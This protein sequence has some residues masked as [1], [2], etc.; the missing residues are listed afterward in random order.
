MPGHVRTVCLEFFGNAQEAVPSIVEIKNYLDKKPGGALLAG[1]E[2]LDERYLRAVGYGTKSKRGS[3]PKMVLIGDIV[4]DDDQAVAKAASEVIR[5]ANGHA[6]E[7]FVAISPE[8]RKAFWSERARTAAIARHTN[9]FKINEDVV[10]P[11]PRMGEYTN[12]IEHINIELS[13][14]NKLK[15]IT[16]C[17]DV[18]VASSTA[19][20]LTPVDPDDPDDAEDFERRISLASTLLE[21]THGRWA[22]LLANLQEPV[23]KIRDQLVA[24]EVDLSQAPVVERLARAPDCRLVDLIQEHHIRVSWKRELREPMR[25]IFSGAAFAALLEKLEAS[26]KA[27]LRSRVFIALHLHAGDGN[28]HT[29][30]PVNSDDYEMLQEA[31]RAV[32]RVMEI[33]KSLDG[34]I[35]GEHGIGITKMEFLTEGE[36]NAFAEYK[37]KVDP[38]QHFNAGK[39]LRGGNLD[40]AYTPSFGLMGAESL[41]MQQSDIGSIADSFANCLRCGK[42]K[43]VCATHVPRANLLYSPRDKIL[44][45]SLL[46]EAFLYE[47]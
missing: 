42:C 44:A 1:L 22:F 27:I 45:T 18:L 13:I 3:L 4:G 43:P 46:I 21:R 28:V 36:L 15:I 17:G 20:R 29:N 10:I 34:V 31:H 30:I 19:A 6:G 40:N 25:G 5:F 2:H 37:D 24:H 39:L 38:D 33:A 11:L 47:E 32:A 8:A 26:H 7:G 23:A 41:I 12:A 14:S 16:A 9:A 35:S